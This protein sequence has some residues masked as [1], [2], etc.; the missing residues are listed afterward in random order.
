MRKGSAV[1]ETVTSPGSCDMS[2][3]ML[4]EGQPPGA[5]KCTTHVVPVQVTVSA[6]ETVTLKASLQKARAAVML[7]LWGSLSHPAQEKVPASP[8]AKDSLSSSDSS[9]DSSSE[10][11]S[12]T[13]ALRPERRDI[14]PSLDSPTGTLMGWK[15]FPTDSFSRA[16]ERR[17]VARSGSLG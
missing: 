8:A 4:N 3:V 15:V 13:R 5:E 6:V 14:L 17:Q 16:W 9:S 2:T 7:K 12:A 10:S 11:M 1:P